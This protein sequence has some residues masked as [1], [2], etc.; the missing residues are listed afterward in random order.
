MSTRVYVGNLPWSVHWQDL[1]D[2]MRQAGNVQFAEILI[3]PR[4]HRSKGCGIVE[5]S[6][7]EEAQKAIETLN[8]SKIENT[9][10]LIFVREDREDK[11]RPQNAGGNK[12]KD[13]HPASPQK[14]TQ[15][16]TEKSQST[17]SQT[18]TPSSPSSSSSSSSSSQTK[19]A[20]SPITEKQPQTTNTEG[21]ATTTTT[22]TN[23]DK[24]GRQVFVG[25]L[26]YNTSWQDLK[27]HFRACGNVIRAS[28][29]K[30]FDGVSKGQ[31]IVLY[32]TTEGAE[33][34][35]Q[36]LNNTEFQRRTIYVQLDK[37]A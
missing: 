15:K 27:D 5:Y 6:T 17:T 14:N 35:I 32:E 24:T 22:T 3:D 13:A 23:K 31:G 30:T 18:Q 36:T 37:Y 20:E 7:P 26:P 21:E 12:N 28:V 11:K 8:D 16:S 34:A 2:H 29:L 10:R 9:D 1:K 33:K 4:T 19:Q 25:N